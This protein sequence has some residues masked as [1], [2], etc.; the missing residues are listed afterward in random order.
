V[1]QHY[2]GE[3]VEFIIF[4]SENFH[5]MLYTKKHQKLWKNDSVFNELFKIQKGG[6]FLWN[7]AYIK[8]NRNATNKND[9][10]LLC[11]QAPKQSQRIQDQS[12][13]VGLRTADDDG[14]AALQCSYGANYLTPIL[15]DNHASRCCDGRGRTG[16][17]IALVWCRIWHIIWVWS[18]PSRSFYTAQFST[19]HNGWQID[20]VALRESWNIKNL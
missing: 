1:W 16:T 11:K 14:I 4:S 10:N 3:V 6:S 9:Y 20:L 8:R 19:H 18:W 13:N 5:G 7:T 15:T 12:S 17:W 2:S